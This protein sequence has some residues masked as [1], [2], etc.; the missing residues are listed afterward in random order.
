MGLVKKAAR[1]NLTWWKYFLSNSWWISQSLSLGESPSLGVVDG[2]FLV[3]KNVCFFYLHGLS[4]NNG[5]QSEWKHNLLVFVGWFEVLGMPMWV[6]MSAKMVLNRWS[7]NTR[8]DFS[9]RLMGTFHRDKWELII[10]KPSIRETSYA[11]HQ[12]R[13]V[14]GCLPGFFSVWTRSLLVEK[15]YQSSSFNISVTLW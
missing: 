13:T 15:R 14:W 4:I 2:I 5:L 8:E 10:T 1:V 6:E 7:Q 12:F 9:N 11:V 3:L